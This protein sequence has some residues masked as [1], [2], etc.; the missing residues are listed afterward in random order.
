MKTKLE[1]LENLHDMVQEDLVRAE[2]KI[3][4]LD[5]IGEDEKVEGFKKRGLYGDYTEANKN[6][7]IEQEQAE[8]K[9]LA[10][11]LSTVTKLISEEKN[12]KQQQ[13]KT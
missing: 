3:R 6:D 4:N 9:R 7:V 8:I 10:K 2:V 12:G 11:V 1:T 5:D 13:P